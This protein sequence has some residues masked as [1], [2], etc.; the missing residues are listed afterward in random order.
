[1]GLP[2]HGFLRVAA[3]VGSV[4][5]AGPVL[6]QR[7]QRLPASTA[8]H[9]GTG[10]VSSR[11]I[12]IGSGKWTLPGTL[13]LPA[14]STPAPAVVFVHDAG[15]HDRDSTYGPN[16][17]FKEFADGLASRGIASLRYDK[18]SYV[19]MAAM[20]TLG[21]YTT[22]DETIEDALAAVAAL[23]GVPAVDAR[24]IFIA[25]HGLGGMLAPRIA[26]ADSSIAGLV[27]LAGGVR[28]LDVSII[29]QLQYLADADGIISDAERRSLEDARATMDAVA[30]LTAPDVEAG[31]VLAGAPAAYWL[32]LRGYDPPRVAATLKQRILVLQGARD[33]QVSLA[34]YDRWKSALGGRPTAAFR[35]YDSL[36]HIFLPGEGRSL[37]AEYYQPA[38]IPAEVFADLA[39]FIN[40]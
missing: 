4:C 31:V 24:R 22:K 1:V 20:A 16:K 3:C 34:D 29:E 10:T 28:P 9:T 21:Q 15:P 36:N 35:L 12:T 32:D 6:A 18:R 14:S 8:Q 23:K 26:V 19:H 5:L 7:P 37:P 30:K 33:Y 40:R 11:D 17:L 2:Q 13:T 39:E 25:G 27:I 38:R